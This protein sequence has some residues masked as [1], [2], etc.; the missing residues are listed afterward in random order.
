VTNLTGKRIAILATNGFEQSEL[1]EPQR[2]LQTAGAE[3]RVVSL[4]KG[5]I[6]GWT[7]NN[8]GQAVPVDLTIDEAQPDDFD[9]LLLPGGVMNPDRLR[10]SSKAVQFARAFFDAHKPIAAICHGPG[11]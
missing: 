8:W 6:K 5:E 1:L 9:G 7:A 10:L 4:E 2:A 3:T 11:C